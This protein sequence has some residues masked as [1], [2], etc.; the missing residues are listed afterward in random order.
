RPERRRGGRARARRRARL[1]LTICAMADIAAPSW[2]PAALNA[3]SREEL[4]ELCRTLP[5][6][7]LEEFD[8]E[9]DGYGAVYLASLEDEYLRMGLGKWLGKGYRAERY[10]DWAGHGYNLWGTKSGVVRSIKFGW[11]LGSS[12]LDGGSC[13]VMHYSVFSNMYADLDVIDE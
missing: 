6:P 2:T 9:F 4:I 13:I 5:A 7:T 1:E 11:G 12:M 8:G 3:L 10:G